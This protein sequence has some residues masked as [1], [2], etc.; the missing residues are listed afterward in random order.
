MLINFPPTP[1]LL[2]SR[3]R[4]ALDEAGPKYPPVIAYP[5]AGIGGAKAKNVPRRI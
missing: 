4:A 3:I 1:L 5:T 2:N